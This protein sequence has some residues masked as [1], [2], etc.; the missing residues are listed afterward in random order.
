MEWPSYLTVGGMASNLGALPLPNKCDRVYPRAKGTQEV[1][2][3]DKGRL[4]T[5]VTLCFQS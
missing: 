5:V 4:P 1:L 3:I 2:D